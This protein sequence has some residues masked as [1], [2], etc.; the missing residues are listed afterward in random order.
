M[1]INKQSVQL[2]C[3]SRWNV[4]IYIYTHIYIYIACVCYVFRAHSTV[5]LQLHTKFFLQHPTHGTATN[6]GITKT[7]LYENEES[8]FTEIIQQRASRCFSF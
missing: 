6:K 2:H 7:I 1:S 5:C 4:Y 3:V 8:G